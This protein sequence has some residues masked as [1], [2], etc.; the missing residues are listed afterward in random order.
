MLFRSMISCH[1]P[2][3]L[4]V[5]PT[6]K[7][8]AACRDCCFE[9]SPKVDDRIDSDELLDIIFKAKNTFSS[10]KLLVVSGGEC[11]LLGDDLEKIVKESKK[12]GFA[13]RCVTN[14]YW[15]LNEIVANKKIIAMKKSGLSELNISTGNNHSQYV[16]VENVIYAAYA[17][18]VCGIQTTI[19]IESA[20][21]RKSVV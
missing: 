6:F 1:K 7:C 20:E 16:P 15:A 2:T 9:C 11:F 3:T 4:T 5:I 8:T 21:D 18:V 19:V 13:V 17:S 14:A 10:L 12:Y